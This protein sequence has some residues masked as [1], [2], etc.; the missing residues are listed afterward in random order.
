MTQTLINSFFMMEPPAIENIVPDGDLILAV[1]TQKRE[2]RVSS[3]FL[4]YASKVF[5]T[6]LGPHWSE[7]QRLSKVDP[8]KVTLEEDDADAMLA[9]LYVL[10]HRN[11]R[12]PR[13]LEPAALIRIAI[14]SDKYDLAVALQYAS[15][16][17]LVARSENMV[18]AGYGL[19]AAFLL[20]NA[21]Q[22]KEL[23]RWMMLHCKES[24]LD[25]FKEDAIAQFLPFKAL[26]E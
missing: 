18:D 4:R 25:L 19:T 6:M 14:V 10:H 8:P 5:N 15:E 7:G 9:I 16:R 23:G 26:C 1:G 20:G 21:G 24:Y 12:V 3:Q 17:W 2:M 13:D 11:D 22:F